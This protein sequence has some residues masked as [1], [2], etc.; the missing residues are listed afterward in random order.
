MLKCQFC[1][2]LF[3]KL[4]KSHVILRSFYKALRDESKPYSIYLEVGTEQNNKK[5]Y[6]A[7]IHD[8]EI[9]CETCER[10]FN[11]FDTH[12]YQ[13]LTKALAEKKIYHDYNGHSCA[14]FIE[15][16]DYTKLKLF[17]LSMLWR[18]HAS[19]HKFF[20]LID[21]GPH[22]TTLCSYIS[23]GIAPSSKEYEVVFFYRVSQ[24]Y[25]GTLIPPWRDRI[26][27][28][29]IYRFYLPDIVILIKVDKRPMPE[30][31]N[32]MILKEASPHYIGLLSDINSS[33]QRYIKEM[34]KQLRENMQ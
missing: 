14:Y 27:G 2:K 20:S 24:Q 5:Y 12:A 8:S 7:G 17:V 9:A 13:V 1:E 30:P 15:S 3:S 6:Q 18:A 34:S 33:E 16:V 29:N 10:L 31:F 22:A 23:S 19:S 25:P 11:S 28:V 32:V 26:Q 4:V 21:L